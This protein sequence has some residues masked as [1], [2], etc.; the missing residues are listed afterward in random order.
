MTLVRRDY[1][2]IVGISC[3]IWIYKLTLSSDKFYLLSFPQYT[4]MVTVWVTSVELDLY[5]DAR[6]ARAPTSTSRGKTNHI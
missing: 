4:L 5:G 1:V 6:C 2:S 3:M